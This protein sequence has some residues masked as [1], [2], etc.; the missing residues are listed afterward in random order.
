M[1]AN[2]TDLHESQ[3]PDRA[4]LDAIRQSARDHMVQPEGQAVMRL[5]HAL[6]LTGVGRG[7]G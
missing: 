5:L 7:A 6:E 2:Q 4:T 3:R 1:S